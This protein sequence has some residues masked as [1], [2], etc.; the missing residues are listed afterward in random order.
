[1]PESQRTLAV[2]RWKTRFRPEFECAEQSL[3]GLHEAFMHA[4]KIVSDAPWHVSDNNLY[5]VLGHLLAEPYADLRP[6][7]VRSINLWG[8]VTAFAVGGIDEIVDGD[9]GLGHFGPLHTHFLW[10]TSQNM[11]AKMP[12]STIREYNTRFTNDYYEAMFLEDALARNR[13]V[14][15]NQDNFKR[16]CIGKYALSKMVPQLLFV[17]DGCVRA[18]ALRAQQESLDW[19]SCAV[20]LYDD[21]VDWRSDLQSGILTYFLSSSFRHN[22]PLFSGVSEDRWKEYCAT[23]MASTNIYETHEQIMHFLN[24]AQRVADGA[25][26]YWN[27]YL[28]WIECRW[29]EFFSRLMSV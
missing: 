2:P 9:V 23:V 8:A 22:P 10:S 24:R 13:T 4:S 1:M 27:D 20:Q 15:W 7:V 28:L 12:Y 16:L 5:V 14:A 29:H 17:Q 25:G 26:E 11:L 21:V 18:E 6:T 3:K 19:F